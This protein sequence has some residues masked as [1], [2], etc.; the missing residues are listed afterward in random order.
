MTAPACS[1]DEFIRVWRENGGHVA[2]TAKA[3]GVT[4]K[5]VYARRRRIENRR[6]TTLHAGTTKHIG[7]ET[8]TA[9]IT[10]RISDGVML[11]GS[12]NHVWPGA[13]TTMQRAFLRFVERMKPAAVIDGGDSFDGASISRHPSIGWEKAPTVAQE[14]EAL[15]DYKGEIER[16][17][18]QAFRAWCAGNHDL[19]FESRLAQQA[20]E[21]AR[22]HGVHLKDHFPLWLPCWRIDVNDDIVIRHR[23]LGGEH[24]DFRNVVAAGKT[25]ITGHDHRTGVVPYRNYRGLHYGVRCGYMAESALDP[26]FVHYLEAKCPNWHPA[27]VVLTFVKGLLL[28]PELVT[29]V[30]D[31]HVQFRGEVIEV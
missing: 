12:D 10:Y 27:F 1:E 30:D 11:V 8:N 17:R 22:V 5:N 19:R 31:T 14:I 25:I 28:F 20:P 18:P 24:A 29:K 9:I 23:E 6:L 4:Q 13:L 7:H 2:N 21:Y 26:Q 16:L 15:K 3:L